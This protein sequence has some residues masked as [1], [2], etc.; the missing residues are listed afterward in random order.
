MMFRYILYKQKVQGHQWKLISTTKGICITKPCSDWS[1]K[2][3]KVKFAWSWYNRSRKK[4]SK[5]ISRRRTFAYQSWMDGG[6]V[7]PRFGR[8]AIPAAHCC[9]SDI[10][11]CVTLNDCGLPKLRD[12]LL[13][14]SFFLFGFKERTQW[15]IG[16][17]GPNKWLSSVR[18][19]LYNIGGLTK[20]EEMSSSTQR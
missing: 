2:I 11:G 5:L 19:T 20:S 16:P 17:I 3:S 12:K 13:H 6:R 14:I 10:Q 4:R 9:N 18:S 7:G 1:R 8:H 15:G